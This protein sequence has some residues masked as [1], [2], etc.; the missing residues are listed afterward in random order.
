MHRRSP[1]AIAIP[2]AVVLALGAL[3]LPAQGAT[4]IP[5]PST[6]DGYGTVL[7]IAPAGQRGSINAAQLAQV[8]AGGGTTAVDGKNAPRTTPTSWRC[9]TA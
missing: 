8:L 4:S 1:T 5:S 9:T 7:N 3:A 2:A 6:A